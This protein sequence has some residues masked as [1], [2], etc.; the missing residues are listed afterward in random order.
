MF[1]LN[2]VIWLNIETVDMDDLGNILY[3]LAML[4]AV[5]FSALKKKKQAKGMEQM[6]DEV[7]PI[8]HPMDEDDMVRELKELFKS[9]KQNQPQPKRR[10]VVVQPQPVN[11]KQAGNV[12]SKPKFSKPIIEEVEEVEDDFVFDK[13]QIDLR[14]AVIYSEILKRPYE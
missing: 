13:E 10:Q 6:P 14:Q 1:D 12:T 11:V 5:I 8:H 7:P 9:P 3:I 2:L 4:A